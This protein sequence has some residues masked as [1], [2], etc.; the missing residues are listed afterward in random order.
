[1]LRGFD[2]GFEIPSYGVWIA[3]NFASK[4]YQL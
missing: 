1:M 2:E 3:K 4:D